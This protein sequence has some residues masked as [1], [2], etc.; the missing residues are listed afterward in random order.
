MK[1]MTPDMSPMTDIRGRVDPDSER[2]T[3]D[4]FFRMDMTYFFKKYGWP[5]KR[6][7]GLDGLLHYAASTPAQATDRYNMLFFILS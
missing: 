1:I 6:L 7:Q 3:D 4:T 5:R 2:Q